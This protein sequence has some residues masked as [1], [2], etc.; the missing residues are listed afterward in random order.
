[1]AKPLRR[2]ALKRKVSAEMSN[3]SSAQVLPTPGFNDVFAMA[4]YGHM[5]IE[6]DVGP[7]LEHLR[8]FKE[9]LALPRRRRTRD[10]ASA[11]RTGTDRGAA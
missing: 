6:G 9:V 2:A 11:P 7:L 8:F 3:L 10:A 5:R 4:R 1:M